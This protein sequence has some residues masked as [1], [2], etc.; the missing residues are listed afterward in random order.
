MAAALADLPR[1]QSGKVREI[2]EMGPAHPEWLLLVASDRVS[3]YDA[4][5]PT[6]IPGKGAV[7]TGLS[8]FWFQ[9]TRDIVDNHVVSI[10][11]GVPEE[12]RGRA[13]LVRRE[14]MLPVECVVRGYLSGSGWRD[15]QATGAISEIELP[16]GLR[17]SDRL[18]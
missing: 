16:A 9:R 8:A 6:P 17:E 15:Y 5:H 11:D 13:M 4:V 14:R 3:T 2:Y 18:P 10:S 12:A 1:L 7:L